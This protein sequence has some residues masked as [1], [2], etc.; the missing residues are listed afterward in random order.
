MLGEGKAQRIPRA[1]PMA[2]QRPAPPQELSPIDRPGGRWVSLY[3]SMAEASLSSYTRRENRSVI[4][5]LEGCLD[6]ATA[7]KAIEAIQQFIREHGANVVVE[8]SRLDFIDSKGVGALLTGAKAARDAGG[9]LYLHN[10]AL[11]VRKILEM[12]GLLAM[13]PPRPATETA[14]ESVTE[15]APASR[16]AAS[17]PAASSS[18]TSSRPAAGSS[19]SSRPA[20]RPVLKAA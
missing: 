17:R 12:C 5:A 20:A 16:P 18:A 1:Q 6:V 9:Q 8:T 11:P 4:L 15:P 13:F 10:P 19:A 2:G 14:A 7:P 3:S